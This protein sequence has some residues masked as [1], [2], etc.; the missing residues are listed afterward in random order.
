MLALWK[1]LIRGETRKTMLALGIALL[2]LGAV[3]ALAQIGYGCDWTG[4]GRCVVMKQRNEEVRPEKTLWDWLNLLIVPVVLAGG[5]I[6]Y[7]RAEK[8]NEQRRAD[9]SLQENALSAYL[10]RISNLLVNNNL[11]SENAD[12]AA[13][14]VALGWTTMV[15]PRLSG[16]RKGV[17]LQFLHGANLINKDDPVLSLGDVDLSGMILHAWLEDIYLNGANMAKANLE[18]CYFW[19]ADLS[20]TDLEGANL[21]NANL[22]E[23]NLENA[24]LEKANLKTFSISG[25]L[26]GAHLKN[27]DLTGTDLNGVDLSRADLQGAKVT[28]DQLDQALSLKGAIMPTGLRHE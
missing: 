27:A 8:K 25:N 4:F 18:G 22:G 20:A 6:L 17:V 24:L 1:R 26:R 12:T 10:D 9:D 5:G 19:G 7:N 11:R 28:P 15:L 23:V 3:V 14:D 16:E 13:R 2:G 21:E